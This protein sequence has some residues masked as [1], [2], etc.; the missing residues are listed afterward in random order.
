MTERKS[1]VERPDCETCHHPANSHINFIHE[2]EPLPPGPQDVPRPNNFCRELTRTTFCACK[3]YKADTGRP[4]IHSVTGK[5]KDYAELTVWQQVDPRWVSAD[6][7][8]TLEASAEMAA[9]VA[10]LSRELGRTRRFLWALV[11]QY[12]TVEITHQTLI[13][14]DYR[15]ELVEQ[16]DPVASKMTLTLKPPV[17]NRPPLGGA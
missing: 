13:S 3:E 2:G 6:A 8:P 9:S 14:T 15:S 11:A 17:T 10:E 1:L 5:R 16:Y 7:L 4:V 12:G